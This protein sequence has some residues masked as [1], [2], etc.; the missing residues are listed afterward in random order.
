MITFFE[1]SKFRYGL[2]PGLNFYRTLEQGGN[3]YFISG[4][5]SGSGFE[6]MSG[7][8]T[9]YFLN[10][11]IKD[12][13]E[14]DVIQGISDNAEIIFDLA[15]AHLHN[16]FSAE[17]CAWLTLVLVKERK[18]W[19]A[20]SSGNIVL[21]YSN[22]SIKEKTN[23]HFCNVWFP[24]REKIFLNKGIGCGYENCKAEMISRP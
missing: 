22:K 5:V 20:W 3:F 4:V 21:L 15:Q 6:K 11:V 18:A 2:S 17:T 12:I 10:Q 1:I 8:L 9:Q 7:Q 23:A 14:L 13:S 24:E 16:D 19:I